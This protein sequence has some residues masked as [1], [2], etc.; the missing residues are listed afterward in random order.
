VFECDEGTGDKVNMKNHDVPLFY[1]EQVLFFDYKGDKDSNGF[2]HGVAHGLR[3]ADNKIKLYRWEHGWP[4]DIVKE[5]LRYKPTNR[6]MPNADKLAGL[7]YFQDI[8]YT[9]PADAEGFP[10]GVGTT[11]LIVGEREEY[12]SG[13]NVY[14]YEYDYSKTETAP[15]VVDRGEPIE[16]PQA[17]LRRRNVERNLVS[18]RQADANHR[19]D[20]AQRQAELAA[21][22]RA[23]REAEEAEERAR[24]QARQAA[25]ERR[26]AK[27][28]AAAAARKERWNRFVDNNRKNAQDFNRTVRQ[29]NRG[30]AQAFDDVERQKRERQ[31]AADRQTAQNARVAEERRAAQRAGASSAAAAG[32]TGQASGR[33]SRSGGTQSDTAQEQIRRIE[34]EQKALVEQRRRIA[35]GLDFENGDGSQSRIDPAPTQAPGQAAGPAATGTGQNPGTAANPGTQTNPGTTASPATG[36]SSD[37][38]S[39]GPSGGKATAAFTQNGVTVPIGSCVDLIKVTRGNFGLSSGT[40]DGWDHLKDMR[41]YVQNACEQKVNVGICFTMTNGASK[42][43]TELG[44][45][46]GPQVYLSGFVEFDRRYLPG[47]SSEVYNGRGPAS[48]DIYTWAPGGAEPG[49]IKQCR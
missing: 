8:Y 17:E 46:P 11:P 49:A 37:D 18:H 14:F 36:G 40:Y 3:T 2:A 32:S 30:T 45:R 41:V 25:T 4:V 29:I 1:G 12:A 5:R 35:A 6:A 47:G 43:A 31:R 16:W 44:L 23:E 28:R 9:G 21:R 39:G 38:T 15:L 19:R 10:H 42:A 13:S 34:A 22:E 26:Q 27:S 48:Y 7:I 24:R 33:D 20:R